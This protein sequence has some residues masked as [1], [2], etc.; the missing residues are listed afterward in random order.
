MHLLKDLNKLNQEINSRDEKTRKIYEQAN[1]S[2]PSTM[3]YLS[4]CCLFNTKMLNLVGSKKYK[5]VLGSVYPNDPI[6]CSSYINY[7]YY[8]R[9]HIERG[10]II[11]LNDRWRTV[12]LLKMLLI[13]I[14][15]ILEV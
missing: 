6:V 14:I 1:V 7:Y 11:I 2:L 15:K 5:L 12:H 9:F 4:G 3:V 13:Y 8:L 10:D